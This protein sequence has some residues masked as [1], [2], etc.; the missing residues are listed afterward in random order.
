M[1]IFKELKKAPKV[2]INEVS[3]GAKKFRSDQAR[4]N[5]GCRRNDVIDGKTYEEWAKH[6]DVPYSYI[7]DRINR[8]G[9]HQPKGRYC[10]KKKVIDGKTYE[11]WAKH[12]DVPYGRIVGRIQD[13]GTPHLKGGQTLKYSYEGKSAGWWSIQLGLSRHIILNRIK[14]FGDPYFVEGRNPPELG[15]KGQGDMV[16]E[17]LTYKQWAKKLEVTLN[18]IQKRMKRLGT[19]YWKG[20]K[21]HIGNGYKHKPYSKLI[22]QGKTREYWAKKLNINVNSVMKRIRDYGHPYN[23]KT[24]KQMGLLLLPKKVVDNGD[25]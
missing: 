9:T 3:Y 6:Y 13:N 17:G 22:Y 19:P 8:S 10:F 14:K 4:Q 25:V 2:T 12:Y 20:N 24:C 5:L 21:N 15:R 11:E 23:K 18:C 16:F 7:L 1:N